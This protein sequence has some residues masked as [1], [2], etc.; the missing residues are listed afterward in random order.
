MVEIEHWSSL[1]LA[2]DEAPEAR[3]G[4]SLKGIT[5][6][7]SSLVG[8]TD[9]ALEFQSREDCTPTEHMISLVGAS[10]KSPEVKYKSR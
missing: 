9:D 2:L 5:V 10:D 1:V 8:A 4:C 7:Q 6:H 3:Y